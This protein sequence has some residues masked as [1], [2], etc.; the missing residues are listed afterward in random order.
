PT[1]RIACG[2]L[3]RTGSRDLGRA[4]SGTD[5]CSVTPVFL[6]DHLLAMISRM[7]DVA[8][9][10]DDVQERLRMAGYLADAATG[11]VLHLAAALSQPVLVEGPAGTGKTQLAKSV[12]AMTGRPLIRLQCYEGLDESSPTGIYF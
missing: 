7:A 10:I 6:T 5:D 9:P 3:G 4:D 1:R 12:A 2:R 8:S 11:T